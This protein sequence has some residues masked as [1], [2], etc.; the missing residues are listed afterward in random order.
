MNYTKANVMFIHAKAMWFVCPETLLKNLKLENEPS[1][2]Y[3]ADETGISSQ[4]SNNAKAYGQ[5]GHPLY[6]QKVC[7]RVITL[8]IIDLNLAH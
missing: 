4:A 8:Y 1:C 3:N 2:I 5:K 7:K 6:Q